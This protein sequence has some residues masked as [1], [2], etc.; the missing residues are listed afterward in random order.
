[1]TVLSIVNTTTYPFKQAT[2]W[3][4]N[5]TGHHVHATEIVDHAVHGKVMFVAYSTG[6]GYPDAYVTK[7]DPHVNYAST[8]SL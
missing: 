4:Q 7:L 5:W 2:P 8:N 6:S 1:M 3:F